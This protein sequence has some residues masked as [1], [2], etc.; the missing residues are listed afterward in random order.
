MSAYRIRAL[1][2]ALSLM[3]FASMFE[4]DETGISWFWA[5]QPV[6][7]IVLAATSAIFWTL[8]FVSLWKHAARRN[9]R[10][11]QS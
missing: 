11:A 10:P 8:L 6:V 9:R 5:A 7:A 4:F 3:L 1:A 2:P